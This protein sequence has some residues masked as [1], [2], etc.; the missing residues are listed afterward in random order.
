[1]SGAV[2]ADFTPVVGDP[3]AEGRSNPAPVADAIAVPITPAKRAGITERVRAVQDLW[4]LIIGAAASRVL[5]DD[6]WPVKV[7]RASG[8]RQRLVRLEPV[9]P[10]EAVV[11][12]THALPGVHVA[13]TV[14]LHRGQ[15]ARVLVDCPRN[16]SH[17]VVHDPQRYFDTRVLLLVQLRNTPLWLGDDLERDNAVARGHTV[18]QGDNRAID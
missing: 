10:A 11:V 17:E 13:E 16:L 18:E 3:C 5:T 12:E 6:N 15:C 8:R 7:R 2:H 14:G 1:M 9:V 4:Q